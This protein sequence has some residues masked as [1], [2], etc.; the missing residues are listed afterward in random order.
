MDKY[1]AF[2]PNNPDDDQDRQVFYRFTAYLKTAIQSQRSDYIAKLKKYSDKQ[3]LLNES[4]YNK[5]D[6]A[7]EIQDY[8]LMEALRQELEGISFKERTAFLC[9]FVDSMT[10]QEVA[11][12]LKVSRSGA[13][14]L[15]TKAI[16]K[17]QARIAELHRKYAK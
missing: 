2:F 10:D 11:Q 15:R 5:V 8:I 3:Q 9:Y 16:K 7:D 12:K 17:L 14:Y 13:Q 4:I 6:E 1:D